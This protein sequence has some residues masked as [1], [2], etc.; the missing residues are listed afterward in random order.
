[1][2]LVHLGVFC[3]YKLNLNLNEIPISNGGGRRGLKLSFLRLLLLLL[4]TAHLFKLFCANPCPY[5]GL[6]LMLFFITYGRGGLNF[7]AY[8]WIG[9]LYLDWSLIFGFVAYVSLARITD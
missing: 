2:L 6:V 9:R 5:N 7:V 1:M 3:L 4:L 8:I